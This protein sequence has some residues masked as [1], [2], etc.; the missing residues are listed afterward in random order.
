MW[1]NEKCPPK[2]HG[3]EELVPH[4]VVLFERTMK[5]G[6]GRKDVTGADFDGP[7]FYPA[8]FSSSLFPT[9]S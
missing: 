7:E 1:F 2:A 4:L 8:S 9:C 3:F 6:C 5:S